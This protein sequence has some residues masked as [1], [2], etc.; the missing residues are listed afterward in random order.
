MG[1]PKGRGFIGAIANRSNQRQ[2]GRCGS[3]RERASYAS[4]FIRL[5]QTSPSRLLLSSSR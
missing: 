3:A 2:R 5:K 4:P 1:L